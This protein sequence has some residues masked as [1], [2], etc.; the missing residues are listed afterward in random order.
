MHYKTWLKELAPNDMSNED[1]VE[2]INKTLTPR[3]KKVTLTMVAEIRRMG[4]IHSADPIKE[5]VKGSYFKPKG[6]TFA[7]PNNNFVAT[8]VQYNGY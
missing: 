4:N 6:V 2:F 1:C 5:L 3:R 8:Q 7:V